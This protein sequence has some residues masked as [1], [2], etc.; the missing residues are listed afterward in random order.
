[1][2][3][4]FLRSHPELWDRP[5]IEIVD[6]LKAADLL[7]RKTSAVAELVA[8]ARS[9]GGM[10][11]EH[12][13]YLRGRNALARAK[14]PDAFARAKHP[15]AIAWDA[16]LLSE[17]AQQCLAGSASGEY[18]QNRLWLAFMAGVRAGEGKP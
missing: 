14:H 10:P 7:S 8:T 15:D 4:N 16:W 11:A 12:L 6:A 17:E 1:M 5:N 18:L 13:R 2:R 3:V 9:K